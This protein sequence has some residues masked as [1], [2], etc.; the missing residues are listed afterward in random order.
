MASLLHLYFW[1]SLWDIILLVRVAIL[2]VGCLLFLEK[3]DSVCLCLA[4][5]AQRS[6]QQC[7][8]DGEVRLVGGENVNQSGVRGRVEICINHQ[9]GTV[10]SDDWGLL[11]ARV[12][13]RQMGFD[14]Q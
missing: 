1:R 13:C 5:T 4:V 8:E 11:E 12:T 3:H 7:S 6:A 14:C 10:C 9:W 2:R